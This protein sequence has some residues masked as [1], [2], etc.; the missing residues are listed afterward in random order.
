MDKEELMILKYLTEK[1]ID[2]SSYDEDDYCDML[3]K[4]KK[5]VAAVEVMNVEG[6]KEEMPEMEEEEEYPN[7]DPS[8]DPEEKLKDRIM[9]IRNK[10]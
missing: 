3:G 4:E 8:D 10:G 2:E 9:K 1:L 5:P 7:S 6:P